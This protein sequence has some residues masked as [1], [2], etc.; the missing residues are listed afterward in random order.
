MFCVDH[1]QRMCTSGDGGFSANASR[2]F[3][4]LDVTMFKCKLGPKSAPAGSFAKA[5]G[6]NG[7]QL[8]ITS[9]GFERKMR[10]YPAQACEPN[11]LTIRHFAIDTA[12]G[13]TEAVQVLRTHDATHTKPSISTKGR[14]FR[15]RPRDLRSKRD[16]EGRR[17]CQQKGGNFEFLYDDTTV[18]KQE[19]Q[20]SE[21]SSEDKLEKAAEIPRTRADRI[22]LSLQDVLALRHKNTSIKAI[23]SKRTSRP[24]ASIVQA[25]IHKVISSTYVDVRQASKHHTPMTVGEQSLLQGKAANSGTKTNSP[26][27]RSTTS[28]HPSKDKACQK[29]K[30]NTAPKKR[31][32]V[33]GVASQVYSLQ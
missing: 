13:T 31:I 24:P 27:H 6:T 30:S 26:R 4:K 10:S 16:S 14:I 12:C 33:L 22:L 11:A 15:G 7:Q 25:Q 2:T 19:I 32:E 23:Y 3:S 18:R 8:V 1:I 29:E 28:E 21:L 5:K 17:D 9:A 20:P